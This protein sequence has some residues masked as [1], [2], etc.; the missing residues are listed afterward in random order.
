MEADLPVCR[1]FRTG[2]YEHIAEPSDDLLR[3]MFGDAAPSVRA[4]GWRDVVVCPI[5][6][7]GNRVGVISFAFT[8]SERLYTP[9]VFAVATGLA[10]RAG[11]ALD[12]AQRFER[13]RATAA[14]LVAAMLPQRLPVVDGW[15]ISA[16][17]LPAGHA[18]CGDWY[19]VAPLPD[20]NLL[21]GVGDAAGHGLPAAALMAEL[22]NAGRGL[23]FAGHQ[24]DRLLDDLSALAC[25]A[26]R[27]N[28][29]TAA[30]GRLDPS[31]GM[32]SWALAGH[33]PPLLVDGSGK[34]R[35]FELPSRPPLG[36]AGF[37]Q[38]Q[39]IEIAPGDTLLLYTDGLIERRGESLDRGLA[40]LASAAEGPAANTA[41]RAK[42]VVDLLC[43]DLSDDCC[44]LLLERIHAAT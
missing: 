3:D 37:G 43:N 5:I 38:A 29:A 40:R 25:Q 33:P 6:T 12:V 32:G 7:R 8:T 26:G 13:E 20:G 35:F 30:Y 22:R 36:T 24:P 18:V 42:R 1:A 10:G 17:Y 27:D 41:A 19:D 31:S 16:T 14:T 9:D 28:F 21:V 11:M 44:L 2:R 15:S 23:G 34:A 39:C 4:L